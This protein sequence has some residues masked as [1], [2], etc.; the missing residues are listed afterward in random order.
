[1][2]NRASWAVTIY[3]PMAQIV[4]LTA[5]RLGETVT[6]MKAVMVAFDALAIFALLRLLAARGLPRARIL[7][8]AWHP[9]PLFE[10]AGS[11]H[12][13]GIAIGLMMLAMLAANGRRPFLAG[14]LLAAGAGVKFLPA[15]VAPGLYRRWDWRLPAGFLAT[16]TPLYLPNLGA[17]RGVLGFLP[18]YVQ[19]EGIAE[20]GIFWLAIASRLAALPTWVSMVYLALAALLL[21]G[22]GL[23][24][25]M[26]RR[27][28]VIA[29]VAA[30]GLLSVFVV[31][32][33]PHYTWYFTWPLPLICFVPSAS[34]V[35]LTIAS[36][37]LYGFFW[38][39]DRPGVEIMLYLPFLL[40]LFVEAL[41]ANALSR[42]EEI[43]HGSRLRSRLGSQP[44]G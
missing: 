41:R 12:L 39:V 35:W 6:V 3:P 25:I 16:I 8:Y 2:I 44:A 20:S 19:E 26:R 29:P 7:L 24:V 27:P 10:F 1:M 22:L 21:L 15:L 4:F 37:V 31:A 34:L 36:P 14:V 42:S 13:D 32:I 23:A 33:T 5:T 18:G 40:I 17:G 30:L 9:L 11:G 38:P 28:D 43:G